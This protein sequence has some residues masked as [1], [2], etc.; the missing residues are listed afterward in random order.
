MEE[1]KMLIRMKKI[2]M[3]KIA[4]TIGIAEST[5]YIWMR[6]YNAVHYDKIVKAIEEID[7]SND[8]SNDYLSLIPT[9]I[10]LE[11]LKKRGVSV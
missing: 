7:S 11:E 5:L 10:L 1:L 6:K 9:E 4:D 3:W 2:P 8:L